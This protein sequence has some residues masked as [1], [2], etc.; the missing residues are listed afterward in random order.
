MPDHRTPSER[1]MGASLAAHTSWARTK[2]RK[3][4]TAA[5]RRALDER[6]ERLVD[7]GREMSPADRAAAVENARAAHYKR[8]ALASV[9]ARRA[10][11]DAA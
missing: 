6:F 8:M 11:R 5:A 1:S 10:K 3:A 4:R 7:P 9:R 2:D